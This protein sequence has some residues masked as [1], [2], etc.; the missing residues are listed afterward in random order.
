MLGAAWLFVSVLAS[1]SATSPE[2]NDGILGTRASAF[3]KRSMLEESLLQTKEEATTEKQTADVA[4][5]T[6]KQ[7]TDV[8]AR[9]AEAQAEEEGKEIEALE[10]NGE[11]A[12][13]EDNPSERRLL[14]GRGSSVNLLELS[15]GERLGKPAAFVDTGAA[16]SCDYDC[17]AEK[18]PDLKKVWCG[19]TAALAAHWRDHGSKPKENRQCPSS[20]TKTGCPL[21]QAQKDAADLAMKKKNALAVAKAQ[22]VMNGYRSEAV[23]SANSIRNTWFGDYNSKASKLQSDITN[24]KNIYEQDQN[25]FAKIAPVV[26]AKDAE[27][28]AILAQVQSIDKTAY[29]DRLKEVVRLGGVF[30]SEAKIAQQ[31]FGVSYSRLVAHQIKAMKARN[32]EYSAATISAG[33]QKLKANQQASMDAN[34]GEAKLLKL[35][36]KTGPE[37]ANDLNELEESQF[38]HEKQQTAVEEAAEAMALTLSNIIDSQNPER[39][40]LEFA[41]ERAEEPIEEYGEE[42]EE[43]VDDLVETYDEGF[44]DLHSQIEDIHDATQEAMYVEA[45]SAESADSELAERGTKAINSLKYKGML[46]QKKMAGAERAVQ[47]RV[48]GLAVHLEKLEKVTRLLN[49]VQSKSLAGITHEG[50]TSTDDLETKYKAKLI[51]AQDELEAYL[52][53]IAAKMSTLTRTGLSNLQGEA[54]SSVAKSTA[55]WEAYESQKSSNLL[56]TTRTLDKA[57]NQVAAVEGKFGDQAAGLTGIFQ[58]RDDMRKISVKNDDDAS[59]IK[60]SAVASQT[61]TYKLLAEAVMRKLE[62]IAEARTKGY[63][64]MQTMEKKTSDGMEAKAAD[65][66]HEVDTFAN[67]GYDGANV[68]KADMVFAERKMEE[69]LQSLITIAGFV[70][71]TPLESNHTA[72]KGLDDEKLQEISIADI[73]ATLNKEATEKFNVGMEGVMDTIAST[74][75][76]QN[77]LIDKHVYQINKVA[78]ALKEKGIAVIEDE[79]VEKNKENEVLNS[80]REVATTSKASSERFASEVD[81]DH[82]QALREIADST[83]KVRNGILVATEKRKTAGEMEAA[84]S[85]DIFA[86]YKDEVGKTITE[87]GNT[88]SMRTAGLADLSA[89]TQ[90]SVMAEVEQS[91]A[92]MQEGIADTSAAYVRTTDGYKAF[93]AYLEGHPLAKP[94]TQAGD[95][96]RY[97]D[98]YKRKSEEESM[99]VFQETSAIDRATHSQ[100]SAAAA[101]LDKDIA[102]VEGSMNAAQ[103]RLDGDRVTQSDSM[104]S[105]MHDIEASGKESISHMRETA[106][107][108]FDALGSAQ[109]EVE[110][111]SEALEN[112]IRSV[113]DSV[114]GRIAGTENKVS[115][116]GHDAQT[117][118]SHEESRINVIVNSVKRQGGATDHEV[119]ELERAA[120][121][122][123]GS[124]DP[125]KMQTEAEMKVTELKRFLDEHVA[126]SESASKSAAKIIRNLL[127]S[128]NNEIDMLSEKTKAAGKAVLEPVKML[129]Q[130]LDPVNIAVD[131]DVSWARGALQDIHDLAKAFDGHTKQR[132]QRLDHVH[133]ATESELARAEQM[134]GF[135]SG[136]GLQGVIDRLHQAVATDGSI[137]TQVDEALEPQT[138]QWRTGINQVFDTLGQSLDLDAISA[139]AS[140]A[141]EKRR[142]TME[143]MQR[144]K[145][146]VDAQI[147]ETAKKETMELSK[148]KHK[149]DKAIHDA[150][151][152]DDIQADQKVQT[153]QGLS[154]ETA[155]D[156][157]AL[158][159]SLGSD[160]DRVRQKNLEVV[161]Q[162]NVLNQAVQRADILAS[163]PGDAPSKGEQQSQTSALQVTIDEFKAEQH[164]TKMSLIETAS[165][166]S[167]S[168]KSSAA[169]SAAAQTEATAQRFHAVEEKL[170]MLTSKREHEDEDI[171]TALSK[172]HHHY[173]NETATLRTG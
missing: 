123:I 124:A 23:N 132:K 54:I 50:A 169:A 20:C 18:Y 5:D 80:L 111:E 97:M 79:T 15:H 37:M 133:E 142:A 17:Y 3:A 87:F 46:Q 110:S 140:A 93:V 74:K 135:A 165:T 107:G 101:A 71:N 1:L 47:N 45:E 151:I 66:V 153:L 34:N 115:S 166:A 42:S 94:I 81:N 38:D 131:N 56:S 53:G 99:K 41:K 57:L 144:A 118:A 4:A 108:T 12:L 32:K 19:N 156:E 16:G 35:A 147:R 90:K 39:P 150:K 22:T 13:M 61:D 170:K 129:S 83:A 7:N 138:E 125:A 112:E 164:R 76:K 88:V 14:N 36:M 121:G 63:T 82:S 70:R 157:A 44:D 114:G 126:N 58:Q 105:Q 60:D 29:D 78:D 139:K 33:K 85:A 103:R 141:A 98:A 160:A 65:L 163:G 64:A 21:T 106:R 171:A 40:S 122:A 172:L 100:V 116:A 113:T 27:A 77:T 134:A 152:N 49:E 75:L 92:S 31:E 104:R 143:A 154:D 72:S 62:D 120:L 9:S 146:G 11:D 84:Q 137:R 95:A 148:S 2:I 127:L 43:K 158:A 55:N 6:K 86:A 117:E 89:R 119:A 59:I 26:V 67:K 130:E 48:P 73:G 96:I 10:G 161:G 149:E 109:R 128:T 136:E 24:V 51:A 159:Y 162:E 52:R 155:K 173:H 25:T 30:D 168:T 8:E 167:V 102:G 28:K 91:H 69:A 68:A 145:A